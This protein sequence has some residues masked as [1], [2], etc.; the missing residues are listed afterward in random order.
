MLIFHCYSFLV[1]FNWCFFFFFLNFNIWFSCIFSF[2]WQRQY[3][4]V[5]ESNA[6]WSTCTRI[7]FIWQNNKV[8]T[9]YLCSLL[10]NNNLKIYNMLISQE[11]IKRTNKQEKNYNGTFRVRID[12]VG[13]K[14]T[15]L[16]FFPVYA[17]PCIFHQSNAFTFA[18]LCLR[19]NWAS[20]MSSRVFSLK[21]IIFL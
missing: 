20:G 15:T 12:N 9:F 19:T 5:Q 14:A 10:S 13:S 1:W 11:N 18:Q 2:K 7:V 4:L 17:L 16:K 21:I 3:L 8:H 6:Q